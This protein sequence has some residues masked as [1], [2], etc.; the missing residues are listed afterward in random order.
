MVT[1][2]QRF[3]FEFFFSAS[4]VYKNVYLNRFN[5]NVFF[6]DQN[7]IITYFYYFHLSY[8]NDLLLVF[9]FFIVESFSDRK[10]LFWMKNVVCFIYYL[11]CCFSS[12]SSSSSSL[13]L[14]SL[15]DWFYQLFELGFK[16]IVRCKLCF[17]IILVIS[18]S[19]LFSVLLLL[20]FVDLHL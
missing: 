17:E 1:Y 3:S 20:S 18:V 6:I 12:S 4:C 16:I 2:I 7:E 5:W 14:F 13:L 15:Y 8:T 19:F 11:F 9:S 10:Q